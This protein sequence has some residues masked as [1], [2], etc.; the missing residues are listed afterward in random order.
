[1]VVVVS[2]CPNSHCGR[3]RKCDGA[4]WECAGCKERW[5]ADGQLAPLPPRLMDRPAKPVPPPPVAPVVAAPTQIGRSFGLPRLS[6]LAQVAEAFGVSE[7]TVRRW[8]ADGDIVAYRLGRRQIRIDT[9]SLAGL[10][11]RMVR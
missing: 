3:K 9:E 6:S 8:I 10:M 2:K 7:R 11:T 1:M 4:F 5:P